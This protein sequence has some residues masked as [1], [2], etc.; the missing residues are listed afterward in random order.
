MQFGYPNSIDYR[1]NKFIEIIFECQITVN[2]KSNEYLFRAIKVQFSG[3][4]NYPRTR[5]MLYCCKFREN[6]PCNSRKSDKSRKLYF[7]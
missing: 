6:C 4:V 7:I 2:C 5:W 1:E 3:L